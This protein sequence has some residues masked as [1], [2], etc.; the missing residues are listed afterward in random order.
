[1]Q[2]PEDEFD[3]CEFDLYEPTEV[4]DTFELSCADI[5]VAQELAFLNQL[6]GAP[7]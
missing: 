6:K 7:A 1:M 2:T 3:D 5:T 4:S